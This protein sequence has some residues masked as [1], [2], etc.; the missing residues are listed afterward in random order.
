MTAAATATALPPPAPSQEAVAR[1][2]WYLGQAGE[3][4]GPYAFAEM[5]AMAGA[6]RVDAADL[7]WRPGFRHWVPADTIAGLLSPP[8][9]PATQPGRAAPPRPALAAAPAAKEADLQPEQPRPS[10]D[11]EWA[12]AAIAA[13]DNFVPEDEPA[14]GAVESAPEDEPAPAALPDAVPVEE[15]HHLRAPAPAPVP[16]EAVAAPAEP[17]DTPSSETE[18][19]RSLVGG[20]AAQGAEPKRSY[21]AR[22]WRGELSFTRSLL[23]NGVV[24]TAAIGGA[25]EAIALWGPDLAGIAKPALAH[26]GLDLA[27]WSS[28]WDAAPLWAVASARL[29]PWFAAAGIYLWSIVG[30]IRAARNRA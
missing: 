17:Q 7:V 10:S 29:A 28:L 1:R 12:R 16:A 26:S 13:L 9:I 20:L 2:Q 3:S 11:W 19:L 23:V 21:V 30:I 18:R 15:E 25:Y 4:R 27:R 5:V 24:L 6:D 14:N 22:H 8:P